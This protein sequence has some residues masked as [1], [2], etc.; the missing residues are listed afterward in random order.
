MEKFLAIR[1][2]TRL[3]TRFSQKLAYFTK[4]MVSKI[5]PQDK[6]CKQGPQK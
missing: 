2:C 6:L 1:F 4:I 5:T 3:Y